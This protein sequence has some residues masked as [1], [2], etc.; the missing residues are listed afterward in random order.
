V[1]VEKNVQITERFFDNHY[2]SRNRFNLL[3]NQ[4]NGARDFYPFV[5]SLTLH[6]VKLKEGSKPNV[7]QPRAPNCVFYVR[8]L[9][10]RFPLRRS[11]GSRLDARKR[12]RLTA[13][14][15]SASGVPIESIFRTTLRLPMPSRRISHRVYQIY[16]YSFPVY[17]CGCDWQCSQA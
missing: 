2:K 14:N 3:V 9:R 17:V 16:P 8:V 15:Q 12:Y 11:T 6:H 5:L 7:N 10:T 4:N 1:V 13:I